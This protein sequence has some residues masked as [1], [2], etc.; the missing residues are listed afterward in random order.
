M[1]NPVSGFPTTMAGH[2]ALFLPLIVSLSAVEVD[3]KY[4]LVIKG[5]VVCR[6]AVSEEHWTLESPRFR[7]GFPTRARLL[8]ALGGSLARSLAHVHSLA[9]SLSRYTHIR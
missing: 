9:R 8:A 6:W 4:K 5:R 7:L 3:T 2:S 1:A